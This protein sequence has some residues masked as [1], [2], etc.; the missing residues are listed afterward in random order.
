[1]E[2][3]LIT[4]GR[5]VKGALIEQDIRMHIHEFLLFAYADALD[6]VVNGAETV[7]WLTLGREA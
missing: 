2:P 7:Q 1:M 3:E 6:T 4:P 5:V